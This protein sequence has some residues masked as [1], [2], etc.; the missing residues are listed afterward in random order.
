[1]KICCDVGFVDFK[2]K[3]RRGGRMEKV[4]FTITAHAVGWS[5]DTK[6]RRGL[7]PAGFVTLGYRRELNG[8]S[9]SIGL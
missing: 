1:M 2:Q 6:I 9:R 8:M 3:S 4:R 7:A 5:M